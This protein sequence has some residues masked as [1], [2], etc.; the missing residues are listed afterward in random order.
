MKVYWLDA[1]VYIQAHSSIGPY[2]PDRTPQFWS[3][4]SEQLDSGTIRSPKIVYDELT[5]GNDWLAQW[6]KQRRERGL[7]V[8]AG[9]LVQ[10]QFTLIANHV[11]QKYGDR[12]AREFLIGGDAWVIAHAL[13]MGDDGIVVTQESTRHS[14]MKVKVPTVCKEFDVR[15]I[16]TYEMLHVFKARF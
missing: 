2:P 10:A 5:S 7:C 1:D 13:D 16:S 15:C 14:E 6:C 12:K 4:L 9:K 8:I 3:F 11:Y